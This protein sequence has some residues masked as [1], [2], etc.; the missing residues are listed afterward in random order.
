MTHQYDK[1]FNT[2]KDGLDLEI[3]RAYCMEHGERRVM[4]RGKKL[5]DVGE[6]AKR[7]GYVDKGCFKYIVKTHNSN[8]YNHI[9]R[10]NNL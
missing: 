2:Y 4:E 1:Q 8:V 5:E 10:L 6:L 9:T 3:F 7:I